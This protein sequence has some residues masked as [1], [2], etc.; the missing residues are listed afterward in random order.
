M[1][2]KKLLDLE[3]ASNCSDNLRIKALTVGCCNSYSKYKNEWQELLDEK[4]DKQFCSLATV[5]Y[6]KKFGGEARALRKL[7]HII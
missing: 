2:T 6:L 7:N 3:S 4:G 5:V 1:I